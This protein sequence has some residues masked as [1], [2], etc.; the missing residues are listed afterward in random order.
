MRRPGKQARRTNSRAWRYNE[1]TARR[2]NGLVD[3]QPGGQTAVRTNREATE[4]KVGPQAASH[5]RQVTGGHAESE[6]WAGGK[7]NP[8]PI[9]FDIARV[10]ELR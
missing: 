10:N 4:A 9:E 2:S 1:Q 6:G 5:E 3:K 8:W 7:V